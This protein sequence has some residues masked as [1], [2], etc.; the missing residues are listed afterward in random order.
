MGYIGSDFLTQI[1]I[2]PK[3]KAVKSLQAFLL[4]EQ[5]HINN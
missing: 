1:T 4:L 3:L 5:G 2:H